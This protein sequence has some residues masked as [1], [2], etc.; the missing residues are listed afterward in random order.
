MDDYD[1]IEYNKAGLI[2]TGGWTFALAS[3]VTGGVSWI[4]W[5]RLRSL[6]SA[7]I[8]NVR[9]YFVELCVL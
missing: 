2:L 9:S 8:L 6:D 7:A 4:H 3:I 5:Q 1:P